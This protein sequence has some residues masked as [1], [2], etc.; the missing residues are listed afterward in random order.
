MFY[1]AAFPR[2]DPPPN[3]LTSAS[4]AAQLLHPVAMETWGFRIK[5]ELP[6]W[7]REMAARIGKPL[8][9]APKLGITSP[10]LLQC[11]RDPSQPSSAAESAHLAAFA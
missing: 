8:Y 4:A 3:T 2:S 9:L 11:I 5:K 1:H 10:R 7:L 6:R